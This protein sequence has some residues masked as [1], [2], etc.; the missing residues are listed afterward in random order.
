MTTNISDMTFGISD[1]IEVVQFKLLSST[2]RIS[3]SGGVGLLQILCSMLSM[4]EA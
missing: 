3:D 4:K 1:S 2:T